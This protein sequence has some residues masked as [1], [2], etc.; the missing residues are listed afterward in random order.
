MNW[1]FGWNKAQLYGSLDR[2]APRKACS[3][4]MLRICP[5]RPTLVSRRDGDMLMI[6]METVIG[7]AIATGTIDPL[8]PQVALYLARDG[9]GRQTKCPE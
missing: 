1:P 3:M 7:M 2:M 9:P 4:T 8:H 5:T 6:G